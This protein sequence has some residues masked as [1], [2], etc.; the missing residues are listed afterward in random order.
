MV[1]RKVRPHAQRFGIELKK[2]RALR[3]RTQAHV[4]NQLHVTDGL[5]SGFEKGT[6]WP[7][8]DKVQSMDKFLEAG[9]RLVE[10]WVN[11]SNGSVYPDWLS[12]LVKAEKVATAVK[13]WQPLA[14]SGLLQ[15]KDY[16]R[17]LVRATNRLASMEQVEEVVAGRMSRQSLWEQTNHPKVFAI[18]NEPVLLPPTGSA[19]IMVE[20]IT[21]LVEMVES[22][23]LV[24]QIV[25]IRTRFHPG[26][27]GMFVLLSFT[28]RPDA[29]YMEDAS[30]GTMH[31]DPEKMEE[32]RSTFGNLQGVAWS[33]ED[34][35]RRLHEIR[36]DHQH[37][38]DQRL[39]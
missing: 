18:I 27:T 39:A 10:L 34:S 15:T 30:S 20:Q 36:K 31:H 32:M 6:H 24:L 3:S 29:L 4:A 7:S 11:L 28:D 14:I 25:P 17:A 38:A 33:P 2:H 35:L 13:G 22:Y 37:E 21:R 1:R 8:Q 12:E 9:G 5:I 26:H 23:R 19:R 16:A